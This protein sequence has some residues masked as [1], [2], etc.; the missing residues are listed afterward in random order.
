R[1]R[2]QL[3]SDAIL[4]ALTNPSTTVEARNG[5]PTAPDVAAVDRAPRLLLRAEAAL[6]LVAAVICFHKLD[7]AW[8]VFAA[9]FIAPD[10]SFLG[11]SVGPRIGA[12]VYNVVHTY[13]APAAL[14]AIGLLVPPLLPIS[15]IWVAHIAADRV[16]GY[17]LKYPSAFG[18]TH[19]G[20]GGKKRSR[21]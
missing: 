3:V 18:E 1:R 21:Q 20:R 5:P 11:Y 17:G 6:V 4:V 19:L 13:L 2:G 10:L 15:A 16:M 7:G 14:A 9:L 12:N 8:W